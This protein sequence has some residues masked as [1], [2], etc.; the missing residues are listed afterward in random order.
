MEK[1]LKKQLIIEPSPHI[2]S[3]NSTKKIMTSVAIAT[4]PATL[5]SSYIFGPRALLL[6]VVCI[7]SCVFFEA[8]FR[9]IFKKDV[10]TV[11]DFSA[12][13]TGI[14]LAFNLPVS[15]PLYMAVIGSFAAI[16]V[17]KEMFGGLG[18]NFANPAIV[19]RIVLVLSFPAHMSNYPVAFHHR[20]M[21]LPPYLE[22][23]T[24]NASYADAITAPTPLALEKA[25]S[26]FELFFG[27]HGGSLGETCAAALL[28]GFVC[29]LAMRIIR[30]ITPLV[31]IGT[32]AIG[33]YIASG[34]DS[35]ASLNSIL[36][37]GLLLG[38]I[39]M[40]TDYATNPMT[41]YGKMLF[42]FGCGLITF[43]IR[44]YGGMNEGVAFSILTMNILT[45]FIDKITRPKPFGKK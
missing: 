19:G 14:L 8:A 1:Y 4:I 35:M 28:I 29:L 7:S 2:R 44:Q 12:V 34:G 42:G 24:S 32:V 9:W 45:P 37:G 31:F 43:I 20:G 30:P 22:Q 5:M 39:F 11:L 13:V 21:N 15:L 36:T 17:V 26:L 41:L 16:V 38:A 25:P 27:F 6:I 23:F 40:A 10:S 3:H 33:T 18:Q